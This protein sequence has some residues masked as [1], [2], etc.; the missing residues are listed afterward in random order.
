MDKPTFPDVLAARY[1]SPELVTVW[2]PERK[3]VLERL[4]WLA[5]LTAQTRLGVPVPD[6]VLADY[7]REAKRL[8]TCPMSHDAI[9]RAFELAALA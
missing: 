1:A 8:G 5:V 4:L 3:V 7:R 9:E 2:S 6:S